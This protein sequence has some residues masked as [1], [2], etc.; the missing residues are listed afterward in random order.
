MA[1]VDS[2]ADWDPV[3]IYEPIPVS[4]R[5]HVTFILTIQIGSLRSQ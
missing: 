2:I 3:T 5:Y 1:E 4:A